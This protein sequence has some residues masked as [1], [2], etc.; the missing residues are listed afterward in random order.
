MAGSAAGGPDRRTPAGCDTPAVPVRPTPRRRA[1]WNRA[2]PPSRAGSASYPQ[3]ARRAP[4]RRSAGNPSCGDSGPL[5]PERNGGRRSWTDQ[6]HRSAP[7]AQRIKPTR[8]RL[9]CLGLD[10]ADHRRHCS[11][12]R[13][14]HCSD[15]LSPLPAHDHAR[16]RTD[17]QPADFLPLTESGAVTITMGDM[18]GIP[19]PA[20]GTPSPTSVTLGTEVCR[21]CGS[22]ADTSVLWRAP[23]GQHDPRPYGDSHRRLSRCVVCPLPLGIS[24]RAPLRTLHAADR[25]VAGGNPGASRCHGWPR[26]CRPIPRPCITSSPTPQW[27]LDELRRIRLR[28]THEALAGRPVTLSDR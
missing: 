18:Q 2:N 5:L 12:L 1:V 20:Q 6:S 22:R 11:D 17:P 19:P 7:T 24:P 3:T 13:S 10:R 15:R 4:L 8:C 25:G 28:L 9:L 16:A 26:R 23:G 21:E 14:A 27:S